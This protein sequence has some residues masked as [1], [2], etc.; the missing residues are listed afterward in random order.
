MIRNLCCVF[1][2]AVAGLAVAPSAGQEAATER[3]A[4][5]P[6]VPGTLRLHVRERKETPPGSKQFK[7]VER[8]QD[9]EV[10]KTAIIVI[11]AWDGHFCRSAAQRLG[12]MVPRMNQVLTAARNHGVMVIFAP[13]GVVNMYANLP[14]RKRMQQAPAA[15]APAGWAFEKWCNL[16]PLARAAAAGRYEQVR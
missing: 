4:N 8:T 3:V 6:K 2:A 10:S 5:R 14:N 13:S 12:V 1:V 9:W 16:D 7:V 11:D 15:K